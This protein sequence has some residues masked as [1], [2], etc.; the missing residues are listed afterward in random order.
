[1]EYETVLKEFLLWCSQNALPPNEHF[2]Y[3]TVSYWIQRFL[4]AKQ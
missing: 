1:M 4:A 2:P 3:G